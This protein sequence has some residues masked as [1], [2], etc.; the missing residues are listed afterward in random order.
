MKFL[1]DADRSV[2]RLQR[3]SRLLQDQTQSQLVK[4]MVKNLKDVCRMATIHDGEANCDMWLFTTLQLHLSPLYY[5]DD[6]S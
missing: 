5:Y 1:S 2:P 3:A 4:K 6:A